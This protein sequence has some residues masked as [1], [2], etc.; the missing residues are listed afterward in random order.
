MTYTVS[1]GALNSSHSLTIERSRELLSVGYTVLEILTCV[2]LLS[3]LL[4]QAVDAV[5]FNG[6]SPSGQYFVAAAARRHNGL[7]QTLLYIRVSVFLAIFAK[8]LCELS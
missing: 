3:M 6:G 8:M 1:G 4:C 7:V 2:L 5:Y